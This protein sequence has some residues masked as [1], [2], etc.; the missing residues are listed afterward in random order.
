LNKSFQNDGYGRTWHGYEDLG[1]WCSHSPPNIS[2]QGGQSDESIA[3]HQS[4]PAKNPIVSNRRTDLV[5]QNRHVGGLSLS[6]VGQT[7]GRAGPP[8]IESESSFKL[9]IGSLAVATY[10]HLE[11]V[12]DLP[13]H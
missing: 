1:P 12:D 7:P 13:Q 6:S 8:L 10:S 4:F 5:R 3:P 2:V 9:L 11:H